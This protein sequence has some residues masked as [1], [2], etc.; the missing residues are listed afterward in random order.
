LVGL[1]GGEFVGVLLGLLAGGGVGGF[2][3]WGGGFFGGWSTIEVRTP[4]RSHP[5]PAELEPGPGVGTWA[6]VN[7]AQVPPAQR[8][9]WKKSSATPCPRAGLGRR[10]VTRPFVPAGTRAGSRAVVRGPP[11]RGG[12][13]PWWPSGRGHRGR[14][15]SGPGQIT[16]QNRW[17]C[18]PPLGAAELRLPEPSAASAG[19]WAIAVAVGRFQREML[20]YLCPV[21]EGGRSACG[22]SPFCSWRTLDPDRLGPGQDRSA[23]LHGGP[24]PS[25]RWILEFSQLCP[26]SS[27]HDRT[28]YGASPEGTSLWSFAAAPSPDTPHCFI[29][30]PPWPTIPPARFP[31]AV[32]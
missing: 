13:R 23:R 14:T 28:P 16:P 4:M 2:G 31:P 25:P 18:R 1:W 20:T 9:F 15:G 6:M 8:G 32:S 21:L 22:G 11:R 30:R 12:L 5:G 3:W 27:A 7:L 26:R 19:A 10:A 17:F 24:S 29:G